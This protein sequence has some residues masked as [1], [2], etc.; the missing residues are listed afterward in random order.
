MLS[1]SRDDFEN[2]FLG[3]LEPRFLSLSNKLPKT[4]PWGKVY[5]MHLRDGEDLC[6]LLHL[7]RVPRM[8]NLLTIARRP[9]S[10]GVAMLADGTVLEPPSGL[11]DVTLSPGDSKSLAE[12]LSSLAGKKKGGRTLLLLP[13][14]H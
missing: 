10:S 14:T 4:F 2:D 7:V 12:L 11:F 8:P 13:G 5:E 6:A 9:G 3:W 1:Q